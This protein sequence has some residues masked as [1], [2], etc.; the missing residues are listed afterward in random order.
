MD[1]VLVLTAEAHFRAWRA[2]GVRHGVEITREAFDRSFGRT[3]PDCVRMLIDPNPSEALIRT[4]ADEK[5]RMYR[6]LVR[7]EIPLAPGAHDVLR[8]LRDAGYRMGVGSSA[9]RENLDMILDGA[10]IREY[11]VAVVDGSMVTRGKPAPDVFLAAARLL[12]VEPAD[13]TVIE[14]APAGIQAARAAGMTAVGLAT[15]HP[16]SA[17]RDAGAHVVLDTLSAIGPTILDAPRG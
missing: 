9:P 8:T 5:E 14:D 17:L 16:G 13:C 11:F 2:M 1:G 15:T 3:N 6:D 4:I 10:S 7:A 12:G